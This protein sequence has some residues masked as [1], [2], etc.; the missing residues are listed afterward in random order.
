MKNNNINIKK[1]NNILKK[2]PIYKKIYC[3]LLH[4]LAP[5]K[6]SHLHFSD[7]QTTAVHSYETTGNHRKISGTAKIT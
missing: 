1:I 4:T 7:I 3:N 2:N 5:K 6:S